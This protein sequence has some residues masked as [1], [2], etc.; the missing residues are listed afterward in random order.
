MVVFLKKLWPF[1]A[2]LIALLSPKQFLLGDTMPKN[3]ASPI[4]TVDRI[5]TDHAVIPIVLS[6]DN[7][8]APLMYITMFSILKN[9]NENTFCDFYLLVPPNFE[10]RYKDEITK[11]GEKY[12][13]CKITFIDMG[14][15]FADVLPVGWPA[16]AYYR[17]A[18]ANLLPNHVK[19][20]YLDVDI[21]V[22]HDLAKL[23]N[24]DIDGYYIA[25][26]RDMPVIFNCKNKKYMLATI[27]LPNTDQYVNSG[28][29]LMNLDLIRKDG[30]TEK[31]ISVAKHGIDGKK[32]FCYPDQDVLNKMCFSRIKF[33]NLEWNFLPCMSS[34]IQEAQELVTQES[35]K[36][37]KE[38]EKFFSKEQIEKAYT[39]SSIVHF[40]DAPKPWVNPSQPYAS[41]WWEYA[42][43]TPFYGEILQKQSRDQPLYEIQQSRI[44]SKFNCYRCK[45]L[46]KIT[47]GKMRSHY[48]DKACRI[49]HALRKA[50]KIK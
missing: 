25:G 40:A 7:N 2:L 6:A 38:L 39:N 26:V 27:N 13:N 30:L 14:T 43:Q 1:W 28:V 21:L 4:E 35:Q 36:F 50:G 42:R 46:S 44:N 22:R 48:K 9:A 29:L 16:A 18:T 41:E 8:Y 37:Q 10:Q 3:T 15:A 20:L 31:L 19:C 5:D 11:L 23:Y 17:L 24:T 45:I 33:L 12:N 49:E 47:F 32:P 34:L